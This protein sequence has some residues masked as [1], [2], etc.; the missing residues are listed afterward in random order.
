MGGGTAPVE[1]SPEGLAE[2]VEGEG[3]DAGRGE[4]EDA[5]Q[6]RDHQVGQRQVQL[7]VVEGA[8]QVEHVVGEP[9]HGKQPHQHQHNLRQ[10]LPGLHL[11][12]RAETRQCRRQQWQQEL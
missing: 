3:V 5:G 7:M 8:V 12:G 10:S 1:V 9:A 11:Q 4:A 2:Q 6:Q